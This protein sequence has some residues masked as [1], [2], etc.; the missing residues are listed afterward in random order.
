MSMINFEIKYK[1]SQKEEPPFYSG[2]KS[3]L[4]CNVL[5]QAIL[6][7]VNRKLWRK[8]VPKNDGA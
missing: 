5:R 2:A 7:I 4:K 1:F 6:S 8:S 3:H